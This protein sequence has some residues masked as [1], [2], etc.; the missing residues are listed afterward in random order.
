MLSTLVKISNCIGLPYFILGCLSLIIF[1]V[2]KKKRKKTILFIIFFLVLWRSVFYILSSRYCAFFLLLIPYIVLTFSNRLRNIKAG[3]IA[4]VVISLIT[5]N[6]LET[7]LSFNNIYIRDAKEEIDLLLSSNDNDSVMITDKEFYRLKKKNKKNQFELTP[8]LSNSEKLDYICQQKPWTKSIYWIDYY[9]IKN[10]ASIDYIRQF[11]LFS[12]KQIC[13]LITSSKKTKRLSFYKIDSK[14]PEDTVKIQEWLKNNASLESY[15]PLYNTYVF[16]SNNKIFWF[17]GFPIEDKTDITYYLFT[18]K[19][20]LLPEDRITY[21]FD[22][23]R[24]RF[25]KDR[26]NYKE[27]DSYIVFEK[28]IPEDYPIE[29]IDVGFSINGTKVWRQSIIL[30]NA[31]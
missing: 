9:R 18:N 12:I 21:G 13:S 22:S 20:N 23:R 27:F 8:S 11:D 7:F 3:I 1:A 26:I 5:Y 31:L 16:R 19:P 14:L 4:P 2:S 17:I 29:R 28:D 10:E 15:S 24:F 6:Y 25:R 30:S